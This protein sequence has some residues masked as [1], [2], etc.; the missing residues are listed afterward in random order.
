MWALAKRG[1]GEMF[2]YSVDFL[3]IRYGITE[4]KWATK[5]ELRFVNS[6]IHNIVYHGD[7]SVL[8]SIHQRTDADFVAS[9]GD[10]IPTVN[11]RNKRKFRRSRYPVDRLDVGFEKFN[12][13]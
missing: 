12:V 5:R 6:M 1:L 9:N 2:I 4:A 3:G 7:T 11:F 8:M 13:K 10:R